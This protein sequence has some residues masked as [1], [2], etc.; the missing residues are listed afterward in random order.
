MEWSR[1]LLCGIERSDRLSPM[2]R[3]LRRCFAESARRRTSS[4]APTS[5]RQRKNQPGHGPAQHAPQFQPHAPGVSSA[6]PAPEQRSAFRV[7][8]M[9]VHR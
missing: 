4:R 3:V 5:P 7:G 2:V 1:A 6:K 8:C 9:I